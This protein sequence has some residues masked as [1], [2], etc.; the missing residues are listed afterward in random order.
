MIYLTVYGQKLFVTAPV[1]VEGTKDYLKVKV[2]FHGEEWDGLTKTVNLKA[3]SRSVTAQLTA[4]ED[5]TETAAVEPGHGI[6]EIRVYG[7]L[8]EN[9]E[10]IK[11]ITTDTGLLEVR[12]EGDAGYDLEPSLI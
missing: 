12:A 5:G 1:T 9:G 2:C 8:T 6:W 3:E 10:V 11:R 7:E 4:E